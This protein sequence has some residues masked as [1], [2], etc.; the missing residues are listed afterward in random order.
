MSKCYSMTDADNI[1]KEIESFFNLPPDTISGKTVAA[2]IQAWDSLSHATLLIHLEGR[3]KIS[4][5]IEEIFEIENVDAL[6][7]LILRKLRCL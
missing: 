7:S 1:L 3:Y 6:V 5:E 4:F 2:D